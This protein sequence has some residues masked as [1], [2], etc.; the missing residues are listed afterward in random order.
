[1]DVLTAKMVRR[2]EI[3]IFPQ[4]IIEL[5]SILGTLII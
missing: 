1:M 2:Q 5:D 3:K 4:P